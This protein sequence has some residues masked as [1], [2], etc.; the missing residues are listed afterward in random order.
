MQLESLRVWCGELVG[1][2]EGGVTQEE[3]LSQEPAAGKEGERLG[4][5]GLVLSAYPRRWLHRA[6]RPRISADELDA[7]GG[8]SRSVCLPPLRPLLHSSANASVC[9]MTLERIKL[10]QWWLVELMC[11]SNPPTTKTHTRKV[12]L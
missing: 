8:D 1:E 3:E 9:E 11:G 6:K 2:D 7:P 5:G 12:A 10:L 4:A